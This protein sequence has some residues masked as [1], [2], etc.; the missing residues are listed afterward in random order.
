MTYKH[1]YLALAIAASIGLGGCFGS[2]NSANP[3]TSVPDVVVPPAKAPTADIRVVGNVVD[4]ATG[5][6]IDATLTFL[7]NGAQTDEVR[8]L[9]DDLT[10]VSSLSTESGNF[11]F[12]LDSATTTLDTLTILVEADGYLDK[13]VNFDVA[14]APQDSEL[15][16]VLTSTNTAGIT[17]VVENKTVTTGTV[18]E[19]IVVEAVA[20]T[21]AAEVTVP[22]GVELQDASGAAVTGDITIE[23]VS[24]DTDSASE[25]AVA[26][27]DTLPAGL[28]DAT[29]EEV[30]EPVGAVTINLTN[31]DG[32]PIKQFSSP[33]TVV[34]QIPESRGVNTGD[35]LTLKSYD[36]RT[37][38]WVTETETVSVGTLANGF[39]PGTFQISSL[40]IKAAGK[41]VANDKCT[42]TSTVNFTG[43]AVQSGMV[44][45]MSRTISGTQTQTLT[46]AQAQI[47]FDDTQS[48]SETAK[49]T[50]KDKAGNVWGSVTEAAI[51]GTVEVALS[52]PFTY[53][54]EDVSVFASCSND[55]TIVTDDDSA[56][57]SYRQ[58]GTA[59]AFSF[60][61]NQGGGIYNL[62]DLISGATYDVLV[63]SGIA[64]VADYT[65]QIT[66]DGTPED[67]SVNQA[68]SIAT[69]TGA[70]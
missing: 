30:F 45:N 27:S 34:M 61:A 21:G 43:D 68:C 32:T 40:S 52:A 2:S 33:I 39:Y 41:P 35:E 64:G 70:G 36:E 12:G 46:A 18:V 58:A 8:L 59:K 47:T 50:V 38:T 56:T 28:Q 55:P 57:V 24:V 7:T 31:A 22:A 67:A 65:V 62:D 54:S 11:S 14:N 48:A 60:A 6:V 69:G 13:T 3:D 1:S 25:D 4:T 63:N 16:F 9:D 5:D 10:R 20:T 66:A 44:F 26:V 42:A 19:A 37:G 53:V 49:I 23:V 15:A 51:C 29:S 17:A